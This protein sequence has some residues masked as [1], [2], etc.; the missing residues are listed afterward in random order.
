M[1]NL[2]ALAILLAF[3]V[4]LYATAASVIGRLI[5]FGARTRNDETWP[6]DIGGRS[7]CDGRQQETN[8]HKP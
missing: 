5:Q 8:K 6:L 7:P 3:C 4:A 2:G 1:E